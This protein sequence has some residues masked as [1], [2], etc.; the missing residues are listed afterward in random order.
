MLQDSY[1]IIQSYQ[2]KSSDFFSYLIVAMPAVWF[3][4]SNN[5]YFP[6]RI[7]NT[8]S[9]E[10]RIYQNTYLSLQKNTHKIHM[11]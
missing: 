6:I 4:V 11:Y 1:T 8:P 5:L 10:N 3:L 2:M 7:R 9:E